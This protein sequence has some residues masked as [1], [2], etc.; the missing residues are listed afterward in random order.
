MN[1]AHRWLCRS[2]YWRNTVETYILPWVLDGL[3]LGT[4]ILE[5][6]P[7]PG[8]TTDLLRRRV[9]HL[10]CVEI[11]RAFADSLARRRNGNNATVVNQDARAMALPDAAFHGAS[12]CTIVRAGPAV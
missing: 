3:D 5:I 11:D 7:G 12:S 1:L 2:S 6:G 10:T 8:V 9:E 4:N